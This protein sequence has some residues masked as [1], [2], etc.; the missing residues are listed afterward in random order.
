MNEGINFLKGGKAKRAKEEK[1]LRYF[2]AIAISSLFIV[3]IFSALLFYLNTNSPLTVA[4][5]EENQQKKLMGAL[6]D[7]AVKLFVAKNRIKDVEVVINKRKVLDT[8]LGNIGQ[9]IPQDVDVSSLTLDG[10]NFSMIMSSFSLSSLDSV[11]TNLVSMAES[12]KIF[13]KITLEGLSI[14]PKGNTY[15][16]SLSGNLP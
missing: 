6:Q 13:S 9:T 14:D 3:G 7:T 2:Q 15:V 8:I 11:L 4:I 16:V 10:K 1:K 12:K 5:Q